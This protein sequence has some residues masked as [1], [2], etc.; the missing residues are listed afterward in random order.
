MKKAF[1]VIFTGLF[2]IS[3]LFINLSEQ[4]VRDGDESSVEVSVENERRYY[5]EMNGY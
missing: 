3:I 2:F 1:F 5:V 4:I